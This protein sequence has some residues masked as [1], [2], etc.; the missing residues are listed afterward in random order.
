[1]SRSFYSEHIAC[2]PGKH[3]KFTKKS[4]TVNLENTSYSYTNF[5]RSSRFSLGKA[6]ANYGQPKIQIWET[7]QKMKKNSGMNHDAKNPW[8][9]SPLS[10]SGIGRCR[11]WASRTHGNTCYLNSVRHCVLAHPISGQRSDPRN[12][13]VDGISPIGVGGCGGCET[14]V[15]WMDIQGRPAA[16]SKRWSILTILLGQWLDFKLFGITYFSRENKPFKALF[17]DP[18]RLSE[19]SFFSDLRKDATRS[20][21]SIFRNFGVKNP[22][23]KT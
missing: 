13:E 5:E 9:M 21:T 10:I 4:S 8:G 14:L 20:M 6:W 18:G 1:M 22:C 15:W 16:V 17:Q 2:S 11:P 7:H 19:P 3:W 12:G 23:V